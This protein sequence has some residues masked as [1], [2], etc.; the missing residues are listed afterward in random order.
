MGSE[1]TPN[2]NQAFP[3]LRAPNSGLQLG[4]YLAL[5]ILS[6][7]VSGPVERILH[8]HL[9]IRHLFITDVLIIPR[10][11]LDLGLHINFHGM[12]YS[13]C[14]FP[15][16]DC[17]LCPQV[18]SIALLL[19]WLHPHLPFRASSVPYPCSGGAPSAD[20]VYVEL[21]VRRISWDPIVFCVCWCGFRFDDGYCRRI[22]YNSRCIDRVQAHIYMM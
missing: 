16:I 17:D 6:H 19:L 1:I 2:L 5:R 18:S 11:P 8:H 22:G 10:P 21:C 15:H 20:G 12:V 7:R 13:I 4:K 14:G 9:I 3:E